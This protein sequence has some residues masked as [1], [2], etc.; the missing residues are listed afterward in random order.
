MGNKKH[1]IKEI[2]ALLKQLEAFINGIPG[3][4]YWKDTNGVYLGC[5][6]VVLK[7]GNLKSRKDIVGKTDKEVWPEFAE[8]LRATDLK[9]IQEDKV[10]ETEETVVLKNGERMFFSSVKRPLKDENGNIIGVIG[11]SLDIT[12]L[13]EAK[14]YA[15]TAN[16][17]KTQ[18]LALMG[19]ELR[20]PLSG[21]IST[22]NMLVEADISLEESRELGRIIEHSGTYLLSTINTILDHA[23]LEAKKFELIPTQVDLEGLVEEVISILVANA[24]EKKLTLETKFDLHIPPRIITD[25][26][27]LRHILSNLIGNAI[28]YTDK[29]KITVALKK[30]RQTEH[31][32]Q[33]EI[34][35]R[36]TGI[37]IP[38]EKLSYIFDQ[39]SQ[40]ENAYTRRNSRSGTGLGL[41]IVKQFV[42][43]LNSEI[44][45][46]SKLGKGSTFSFIADYPL[47]KKN[48]RIRTGKYPDESVIS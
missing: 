37:G 22:A 1:S 9:V 6:D 2:K 23:K 7:K 28:K 46:V 30:I 27:A 45:V 32:I 17:A 42:S 18:F 39:F 21:I 48:Q 36:D 29:G 33:V 8:G 24:K 26:R 11:N 20:I 19:H 25:A 38:N 15:E 47:P 31:A 13:K 4:V 40:I 3:S 35:V 34:S 44:K 16:Q 5:N 41:S 14:Q 12:E 10:I 43:L